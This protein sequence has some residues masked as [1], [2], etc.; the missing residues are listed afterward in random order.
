MVNRKYSDFY[1]SHLS[2]YYGDMDKLKTFQNCIETYR[3]HNQTFIQPVLKDGV[4]EMQ[5]NPK[6]A[7]KIQEEMLSLVQLFAQNVLHLNLI[8]KQTFEITNDQEAYK[9]ECLTLKWEIGEVLSS[10]H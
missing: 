8:A 3:K 10:Y 5:K 6:N 9:K 2:R 1:V 7:I 4:L